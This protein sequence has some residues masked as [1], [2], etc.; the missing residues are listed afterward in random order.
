MCSM[1]SQYN[2]LIS[3][4]TNSNIP[5]YEI[6]Y[7]FV[8]LLQFDNTSIYRAWLPNALQYSIMFAWFC[9]IKTVQMM[10]LYQ[11]QK[12]ILRNSRWRPVAILDLWISKMWL[13]DLTNTSNIAYYRARN[14][15]LALIKCFEA[16]LVSKRRWP[17]INS[18]E[19]VKT[20]WNL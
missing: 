2:L 18:H 17:P 9:H 20:W 8:V 16:I 10:I 14:M 12:R 15:F 4:S 7:I 19:N 13:R 5:S 1:S 3:F 6:H 11:S